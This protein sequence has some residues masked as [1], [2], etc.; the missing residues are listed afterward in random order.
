MSEGGGC[1]C[2]YV[3]AEGVIVGPLGTSL[4]YILCPFHVSST[5][6]WLFSCRLGHG[7]PIDS[8]KS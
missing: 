4:L 2:E 8:V 5:R 6:K 1:G 3:G 7:E